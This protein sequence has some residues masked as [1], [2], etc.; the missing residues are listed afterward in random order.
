MSTAAVASRAASTPSGDLSAFRRRGLL[1]G[2]SKAALALPVGGKRIVEGGGIEVWPQ[3]VGEIELRICQLPEQKIADALLPSG[4][5]EQVRLGRIAHRQVGR[6]LRLVERPIR[7]RGTLRQQPRQRLQNVPAAAVVGRD[8]ESQ[9]AIF[10]GEPLALLDQPPDGGIEAPGIADHLQ[11]RHLVGRTPPVLGTE[12][13]QRQVF[14]APLDTG[15]H[16]FAHR[17]HAAPVPRDARQPPALRPAPVAVHDDRH[18]AWHCAVPGD[19][20]RRADVH[21]TASSS[22]SFCC[23]SLSIS[24]IF[25]SVIFCTSSW[26][27][28]S[29]FSETS[30]FFRPSFSEWIASRRRLRTA[31]RAFSASCFTTL[32]SSLRRSSV[33]GGIGTSTVSPVVA[34]LSPRSAS[35]IALSTAWIIFFSKGVTPMVRASMRITFAIWLSGVSVP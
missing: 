14:D 5:D 12:C 2:A 8:G 24:A 18:M 25:R 6:E 32:I 27:R 4:A 31:I 33:S 20:L 22:V 9:A 21:H 26:A 13:E 10:G 28:R 11:P 34:G 17:L 16:G 19:L 35:R 29:S 3:R 7:R 1:A 15:A 23:S 30:F